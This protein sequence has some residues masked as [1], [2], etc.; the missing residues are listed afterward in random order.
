ME[1][2]GLRKLYQMQYTHD[3]SEP[4]ASAMFYGCPEIGGSVL[5]ST[6]PAPTPRKVCPGARQF[7]VA[8][9]RAIMAGLISENRASHSRAQQKRKIFGNNTALR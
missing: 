8:T 5:V 6:S 9:T 2:F 1:H 4:T 7:N 3:F